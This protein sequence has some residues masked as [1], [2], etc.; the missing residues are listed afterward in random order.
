M[1]HDEI[2]KIISE[3]KENLRNAQKIY[4]SIKDIHFKRID[5][6][7][8]SLGLST[9]HQAMI[10]QNSIHEILEIFT[11]LVTLD[12]CNHF[13]ASVIMDTMPRIKLAL[14]LTRE[15]IEGEIKS[16]NS[17]HTFTQIDFSTTFILKVIELNNRKKNEQIKS[18]QLPLHGNKKLIEDIVSNLI[19]SN[20]VRWIISL[21]IKGNLFKLN[22]SDQKWVNTIE[23]KINHSYQCQHSINRTII[24]DSPMFSK[25][26]KSIDLFRDELALTSLLVINSY[27]KVLIDKNSKEHSQKDNFPICNQYLLSETKKYL[28]K[29]HETELSTSE[30]KNYIQKT[31][32]DDPNYNFKFPF[33]NKDKL[34]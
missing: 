30:I 12:V 1:E 18:P 29:S 34:P 11:K 10:M 14:E 2:L 21:A 26:L 33:P 16:T 23:A 24:L 20:R 13:I 3:T 19:I 22:P 27:S 4:I 5:E 6:I 17:N 25:E 8:H 15:L 31:F 32:S 7:E 9:L 28:L